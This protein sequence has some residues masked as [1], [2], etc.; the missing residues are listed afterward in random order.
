MSVEKQREE[1]VREAG[2]GLAAQ[3]PACLHICPRS[4]ASQPTS[5]QG[6]RGHSHGPVVPVHEDKEHGSQEK[7]NGQDNDRHLGKQGQ[8]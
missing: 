7:E 3:G 5:E 4:G 2:A 6:A 1:L 8:A